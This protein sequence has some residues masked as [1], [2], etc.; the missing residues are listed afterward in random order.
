MYLNVLASLLSSHLSKV[1]TL[2]CVHREDSNR[3]HALSLV[4]SPILAKLHS[5]LFIFSMT[6]QVGKMLVLLEHEA[7]PDILVALKSYRDKRFLAFP[8]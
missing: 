6:A 8:I 2:L 3:D 5:P 7:L 4:F 1:Q